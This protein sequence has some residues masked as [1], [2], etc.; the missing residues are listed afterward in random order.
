[1]KYRLHLLRAWGPAVLSALL[2][3][4]SLFLLWAVT[5]FPLPREATLRRL[6]DQAL[7]PHGTTLASGSAELEPFAQKTPRFT[8]TLRGDGAQTWVL[9]TEVFG[10]LSRPYSSY[11]YRSVQAKSTAFWGDLLELQSFSTPTDH[12]HD[13][14]IDFIW[15]TGFFLLAYTD[16]PAVA[17]VEALAGWQEEPGDTAALAASDLTPAEG[18]EGV[19]TG[20]LT[21]SPSPSGT[22]VWRLRAYDNAG[23]LLYEDSSAPERFAP[24]AQ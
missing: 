1:M 18:Y 14:S 6:E 17:Q 20:L 23:N 5:D 12:V 8:W 9:L 10:P 19:W 4:I 11:G 7:L 13:G 16:D 2:L 24:P 15:S 3:L 21:Q 22:L